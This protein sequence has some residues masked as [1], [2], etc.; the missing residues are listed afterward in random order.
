VITQDTA[1]SRY[2][3]PGEGLFA[4]TDLAS[5]REALEEVTAHYGKHARAARE[6]AA[7]YFDSGTVLTQLLQ[8]VNR[9]NP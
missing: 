1:W 5:A 2:I 9:H 4:F 6:M 7:A 3:P 8:Q